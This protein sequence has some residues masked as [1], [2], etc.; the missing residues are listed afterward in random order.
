M[1]LIEI[2]PQGPRSL[3]VVALPLAGALVLTALALPAAEPDQPLKAV[4]ADAMDW[5]S[6]DSGGGEASGG[7]WS[8]IAVVGQHDAGTLSGS[9]TTLDG[10]FVLVPMPAETT[11]FADGFES[12]DFGAWSSVSP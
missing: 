4:A 7:S 9:S 10:G 8:V 6:V 2:R 3:W 5:W 12:G 11:L 1:N